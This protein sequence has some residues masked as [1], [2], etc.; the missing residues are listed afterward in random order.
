VG[1]VG[2]SPR[3]RA[4]SPASAFGFEVPW[5]LWH[6]GIAPHPSPKPSDP[7]DSITGQLRTKIALLDDRFNQKIDYSRFSGGPAETV[8]TKM[9]LVIEG[10]KNAP[11]RFATVTRI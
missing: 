10:N 7:Y 5:L 4:K 9:F 11:R 1:G 2:G 6:F 8:W 3:I